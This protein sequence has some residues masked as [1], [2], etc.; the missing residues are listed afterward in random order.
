MQWRNH[1]EG[2]YYGIHLYDEMETKRRKRKCCYIINKQCFGI[3]NIEGIHAFTAWPKIYSV[4]VQISLCLKM[5]FACFLDF[6][7]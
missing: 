4:T 5:D 2:S 7:C 3:F 6:S 1:G